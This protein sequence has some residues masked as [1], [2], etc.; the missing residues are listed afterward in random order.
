M[1]ALPTPVA[2]RTAVPVALAT[3]A[4]LVAG[5]PTV[6]GSPAAQGPAGTDTVV[7]RVEPD[8]PPG[9]PL[10]PGSTGRRLQ[11]AVEGVTGPAV[12]ELRAGH[13]YLTPAEYRDPACG[14]CQEPR[15]DSA[16]RATRGLEL[17]GRGITVR[18][19]GRDSTVI[20]TNAGYGVL[21]DGCRDCELRDLAVTD[22]RRDLDGRAT[23]AG[24]VVRRGRVRL[25]D[26]AIRENIGDSARVD[27]VVVGV[28]GVAVREGGDVVVRDCRIVRNSWDGIAAYRGARLDVRGT[29]VD[30]V[31][32][33]SGGAV[34]GGRGV[35][36][37]LT[38]DARATVVGNL[39]RNY[40][41][42][43]GV[44]VDAE[45]EVR[46]NV[47]EEVLT[48]GIALWDAGQGTPVARVERNA[49]HRTGACGA[50]IAL[51]S[52]E[53]EGKEPAAG[54]SRS[55]GRFTENL[56]VETAG[57]ERYDS[58]KP[59]CTQRP[60]ARESVPASFTV[61][62]NLLHGNRQPGPAR[63]DPQL[64]REAFLERAAPVLRALRSRPLLRRS[65]FLSR[66][67]TD[68]AAGG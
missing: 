50:M 20:H 38:W 42:G 40:W 60:I 43:I 41:K 54:A 3:A 49:V 6:Q 10:A 58:G 27:S 59:Y 62:D 39:V 7:I 55:S 2:L 56:L 46:E 18:G 66:F 1:R 17:S 61:R 64:S 35:G 44:F 15:P 68:S 22:G 9:E 48:W 16:V 51:G 53:G 36:I 45:A 21:F 33:A 19:A 4:L 13:Y 26:C 37:G 12:I 67:V 14:N 5:S 25:E 29:L 52:M 32:R 8:A 57:D 11:R 47:V 24:V 31:D 65:A 23:D 63:K 28:A 30:G 34:G